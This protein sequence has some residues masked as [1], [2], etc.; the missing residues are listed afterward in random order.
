M[1]SETH[2]SGRQN[3][4]MMVEIHSFH[5]QQHTGSRVSMSIQ[6][7]HG[8]ATDMRKMPMNQEDTKQSQ[9]TTDSPPLPSQ[10]RPNH[11]IVSHFGTPPSS[12]F[13][14]HDAQFCTFLRQTN[15]VL[16]DSAW[17]FT[18][19]S[20]VTVAE[21]CRFLSRRRKRG[22]ARACLQLREGAVRGL[23]RGRQ[24]EC[25][26][27]ENTG[28]EHGLP[29]W[30]HVCAVHRTLLLRVLQRTAQTVQ[31]IPSQGNW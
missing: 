4:H 8:Y 9:N 27:Y 25:G 15:C 13:P 28:L 30:P 23:L 19:N 14:C 7:L 12:H 3:A 22:M 26:R 2:P 6:A 1:T 17:N 18:E 20:S 31:V 29:A 16:S 10:R 11:N 24:T 21:R 5:G